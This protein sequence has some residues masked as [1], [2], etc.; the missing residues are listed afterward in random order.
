MR[1]FQLFLV[2]VLIGLSNN[3][4]SSEQLNKISVRFPI[5]IIE[6]GQT[7]FYVSQ[8]KGYYA[9]EGLDV[10]FEMGSKELNPVKM[11]ASEQDDFAILGGPDTLL[12]ARSKGHP[13]KAIAVIHRNSNFPCLI[14]LK[15]SDITKLEQLQGKKI[16]FFYGHIS[17]DVLRNLLRKNKIKYTEVDVGFDYAQLIAGRIDAEWAFTVTAGLELPAKEVDINFISPADYEISTHGYTIFATEKTIR[18]RSDIVLRFV[19]AS[20]KGVKYTLD[21]PESALQSLIKRAPKLN[22]ELNL[23]RQ[24]AYNEVTSNTD[25]FPLGYMDETMFQSTYDRLVEEDVIEKS[26]DVKSAYTV[27]FLEKIHGIS[28]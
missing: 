7:T 24:L 28:F 12:V 20:L 23:K 16:G 5:P 21:N 27:K 17:T 1:L 10:K 25:E 14:T 6:A 22:K 15:S 3:A 8:D 9:E 4:I 18:E 13:L 2:S 26:F 19:R 11:V